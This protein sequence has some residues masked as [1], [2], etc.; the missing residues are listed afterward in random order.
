MFLAGYLD[1]TWRVCLDEKLARVFFGEKYW[2][3]SFVYKW[4]SRASAT[5]FNAP[6]QAEAFCWCNKQ[7]TIMI[8]NFLFLAVFF[9]GWKFIYNRCCTLLGSMLFLSV[10]FWTNKKENQ[11]TDEYPSILKKNKMSV[12]TMMPQGCSYVCVRR[13]GSVQQ[14]KE[15]SFSTHWKNF[16]T[17]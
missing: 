16:G 17:N 7:P 3:L 10:L 11:V 13:V 1:M 4:I 12:R 9:L 2:W 6:A 15:S 14:L 5:K 8:V